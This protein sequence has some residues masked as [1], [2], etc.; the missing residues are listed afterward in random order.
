MA[1]PATATHQA[2]AL[3]LT[4][5]VQW[6]RPSPPTMFYIPLLLCSF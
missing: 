1:A 2:P 6:P 5:A 3:T 4:S